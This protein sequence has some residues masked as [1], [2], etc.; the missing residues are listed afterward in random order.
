MDSDYSHGAYGRN[1]T[2]SA[3][4]TAVPTPLRPGTPNTDNGRNPF[5]DGV[6]SQASHRGGANPF[7]SPNASRP[8]SS[9]GSSSAIGTR[10]EE[11]TQRY[12]HSRRVRKGEVEK[13]W[14]AKKDPRAKWVTIFPVIGIIV[15]LG[16]SGFLIYDG[17]KSVVQHKYCPVLDENWSNGFNTDVWTKEVTV[18]GFG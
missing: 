1:V 12:F 10:Y 18:G 9:F 14:L 17:I 15:G 13:P 8:A 3:T 6:E 5:S 11:R 16:V 7:A 2:P 4:S